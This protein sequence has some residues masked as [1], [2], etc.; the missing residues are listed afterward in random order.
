VA[1]LCSGTCGVAGECGESECDEEWLVDSD[2]MSEFDLEFDETGL[3]G[4]SDNA[5][6]GE[7]GVE[8]EASKG[9]G[10]ESEPRPFGGGEV[11][12][13]IAAGDNG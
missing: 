3:S 9:R 5:I 6:D 12:K 11:G 4:A 7:S 10:S 2:S 13:G 1:G 8:R